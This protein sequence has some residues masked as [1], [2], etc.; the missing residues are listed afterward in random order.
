[1]PYQAFISYSHAADAKLAPALQSA[2]QGFAKPFYRLR[3]L[4][5]FRDDTSLQLTPALWPLIRKSLG[6]SEYFILMATPEAAASRWVR[7]EITEWLTL[8]GGSLEKFNIVLTDGDIVWDPVANDFD[9]SHTTA[10]PE[11][12]RGR[13]RSVPLYLD[14]RWV[15]EPDVDLSLRNPRF[16][17]SIAKLAAVLHDK[18][19]DTIIGDDVTQHRRFRIVATTGIIALCALTVLAT[20]SAYIANDRSKEAERQRREALR[21]RDEALRGQSLFL[22]D[23]AN[24]QTSTGEARLGLLLALEALPKDPRVPDRP[25]VAEAQAA[26]YQAL[27][28]P[29]ESAVFA[30]HEKRV[31]AAAFASNGGAVVTSSL[32]AGPRV[33][34]ASTGRVKVSLRDQSDQDGLGWHIAVSPDGKRAVTSSVYHARAWEVDTGTQ[35]AHLS[36]G[37]PYAG[38]LESAFTD[39][40]DLVVTQCAELVRVWDPADGTERT[41]TPSIQRA[42]TPLASDRNFTRLLIASKDGTARIWDTKNEATVAVVTSAAKITT[43]TFS[44]NGERLVTYDS[45][46]GGT[47]RLWDSERGSELARL[48]GHDGVVRALFGPRSDRIVTHGWNSGVSSGLRYPRR[49]TFVERRW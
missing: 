2:L 6:E 42:G 23:L 27:T 37:E 21:R 31:T 25:F 15:K 40:G 34:D 29:H 22:A 47:L 24:Q 19:L 3:A 12:L 49:G 30:D 39:A 9:W 33:L 41:A 11:I 38:I 35:L 4:R 45:R 8:T 44:P 48:E 13:F 28:A 7:D 17:R 18:P 10:L 1:M 5:I 14:F 43:A 36:A 16:L 32:D 20:G 46:E 26:L